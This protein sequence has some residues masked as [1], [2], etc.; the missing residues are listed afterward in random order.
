MEAGKRQ[1]FVFGSFGPFTGVSRGDQDRVFIH[2]KVHG[3]C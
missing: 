1:A 3:S 2:K